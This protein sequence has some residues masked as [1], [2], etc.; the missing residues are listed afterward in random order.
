ME[1]QIDLNQNQK[2]FNRRGTDES[3][4]LTLKKKPCCCSS[5]WETVKGDGKGEENSCYVDV[6]FHP[7]SAELSVIRIYLSA[8]NAANSEFAP[9]L[10]LSKLQ[11]KVRRSL[12]QNQSFL[13]L[14]FFGPNGLRLKCT[15]VRKGV[16]THDHEKVHEGKINLST[17]KTAIEHVLRGLTLFVLRA[18]HPRLRNAR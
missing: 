3:E 8:L 11:V 18:V 4:H 7:F 14:G 17:Y 5:S 9:E 1:L 13:H 6:D 10:L 16:N 2:P 12:F 15:Q